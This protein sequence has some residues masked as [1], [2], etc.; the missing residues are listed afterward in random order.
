MASGIHQILK[1]RE[2]QLPQA[3]THPSSNFYKPN[4]LNH[5]WERGGDGDPRPANWRRWQVVKGPFYLRP[6]VQEAAMRGA[7]HGL[8]QI[9]PTQLLSVLRALLPPTILR[10]GAS[11]VT[12]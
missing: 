11:L 4:T 9:A 5:Q 3:H 8:T 12:S 2:K 10:T 6:W 7:R 1:W